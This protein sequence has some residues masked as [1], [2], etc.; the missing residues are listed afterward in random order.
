V[1][2]EKSVKSF[3]A[4]DKR[5]ECLEEKTNPQIPQITQI[6]NPRQSA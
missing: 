6:L 5:S 1:G 3:R 4:P 2:S